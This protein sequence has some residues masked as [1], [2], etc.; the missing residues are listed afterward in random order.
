MSDTKIS[1][2]PA[3]ASA[4]DADL[5]PVVQGSGPSATTRRASIAQLRAGLLADR[6]VHVREYGAV[7][8]GVANDAPAIQAAVDAMA[9]SGGG[10]LQFGPRRYRLASPVTVNGVSI[11]FQGAGFTEGPAP[12]DGTWFTIDTTGFTPFTFTGVNTRGCA[13]RDIAVHQT[14]GAAQVPGWT[15][16]A[17]DFVFRVQDCLGSID[18]ENVFLCAVNRGIWIDNSGRFNIQRLRG[19]VFTGGIEIDR[20]YDIGRID[21]VHFWT[22]ATSDDDVLAYQQQNLDAILLRRNDGIFLDDIFALGA[23]SVLRFSA[24]AS[25]VTTKFYVGNLYTDF[26][27]YG[28]WID[29]SGVDGQ[30]ANATTQGEAITPVGAVL[31]GSNGIRI[32]GSNTR[33]H[34]G[35]LRVDAVE[36]N[37]IVVAGS[38]NRFDVFSFRA[39]RFNTLNDGSAAIQVANVASGTPNAVYVGTPPLLS[40][41]NGGP[42]ANTGTNGFVASG[43]PAGRIDRP[44]VMVGGENNG[45]YLPASG[46]IATVAGGTE[47]LRAT[48]AGTV[49]VG[50]PTSAPGFRVVTPASSVNVVEARSAITAQAPSLSAAGSDANVNLTVAAKGTGTVVAQTRG[51]T[52]LEVGAAATPVNS[53]RVNGSATGTAVGVVA[54]GSDANIALALAAK[55]TNPVQ[56]QTRGATALEVNATGTPGNFLRVNATAAG[57][58]PQLI[59]Q[60][61]DTNVG[62]QLSGKGTGMVSVVGPLQLATYTVATLP[63]AASYPRGIVYVSDGTTNKRFAVSDGTSWRWPDGAV[64]S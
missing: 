50:G 27:K 14:H 39:E 22:F 57:S 51:A 46:E 63:A 47:V 54:Q 5:L 34:V 49:T 17:Y 25:G 12:R 58:A 56:L 42:L 15:P 30:I 8:D 29:G 35:N 13:V 53:V 3:I 1:A 33:L 19:Q 37:A 7:G 11:I 43:G 41:G 61:S 9:A 60:G 62:L 24:S 2:L 18:F 52:A 23:R 28:V 48:S 64:V 45:L 55:G 6:P 4:A 21:H 40:N 26:A 16:T 44:G 36:S 10:V 32:D 38:G 20:S 59:A 31:P